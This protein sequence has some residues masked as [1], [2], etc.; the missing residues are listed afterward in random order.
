MKTRLTITPDG[1]GGFEQGRL[2]ALISAETVDRTSERLLAAGVELD[3]YLRNPVLLW[4]HDA[5]L[6][7]IGRAV[8]VEPEPGVG[9]WAVN[10]FAPTPF[11]QEIAG[12]YRDGFLNAFSVGFRPLELDTR[13]RV[14][15]QQGATILRWELVEQSAVA[16]PANPDALVTAA[17]DGNRAAGWLLKT[18]YAPPD[19]EALLRRFGVGSQRDWPTVAAAAFR[20]FA[21]RS[22]PGLSEADG[23]RAEGLLRKLY[24]AHA[25]PF[26][27][28][29]AHGTV[30]FQAEEPV[31]FE[32][33]E[34]AALVSTV[35]G[36]SEALRNLARH[37]RRHG[38][39]LPP[40]HGVAAAVEHLAEV[41]TDGQPVVERGLDDAL[42]ELQDVLLQLRD[43]RT[44]A[45]RSALDQLRRGVPAGSRPADSLE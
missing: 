13:Q 37:R 33:R 21:A 14:A 12:L 15:G 39:P 16:V 29:D 4:A 20:F 35:R 44:A 22:G 1:A 41:L 40:L 6:P 34:L 30:H 7:P 27:E 5:A 2:R 10:E 45:V 8:A 42:S 18:Y 26:P 32:E 19:D 43:E 31:V 9:V 25:Q 11:A 23:E 36:R 17:A 24:E 28:V 38:L 3:N